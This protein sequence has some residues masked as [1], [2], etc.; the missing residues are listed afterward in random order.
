MTKIVADTGAMDVTAQAL[1]QTH[2]TLQTQVMQTWQN[3]VNTATGM[4]TFSNGD[5]PRQALDDTIPSLTRLL[6][7]RKFIADSLTADSKTVKGLETWATD[8]ISGLG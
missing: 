6:A 4:P 5:E 2:Q 1:T 8:I 3:L 7:I